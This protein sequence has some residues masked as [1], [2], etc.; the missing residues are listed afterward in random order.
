MK[1]Y[2]AGKITGNPNYMEEFATA[3]RQLRENG[4]DVM[5]PTI[6]PSGFKYE[7]YMHICF[8]M[9]DVCDA[10]VLLDNWIG[11]SGAQREVD[12]ANSKR[13]K[14]YQ[15][16]DPGAVAPLHVLM[17]IIWKNLR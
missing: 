3:E 15:N 2:I 9:I 6:L 17:S 10:V 12:Y 1:I 4:F 13:K 16:I 5:N 8:A 14:V 7:Q 11:S